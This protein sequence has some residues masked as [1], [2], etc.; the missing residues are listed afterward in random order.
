MKW[1]NFQKQNLQRPN[2]EDA[3]NLNRPRKEAE[4]SKKTESVSACHSTKKISGS[5]MVTSIKHLK[6]D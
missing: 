6:W 3:G 1:T 5:S 4:A 2:Y